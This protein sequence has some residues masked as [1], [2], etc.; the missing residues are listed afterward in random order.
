MSTSN[1]KKDWVEIFILPLVIACVGTFGTYLITGQQSANALTQANS[2][3]QV[4]ILEIFSEKMTHEDPRQ[5]L[6]AIK[7][8][9][10][11]DPELA[12]KMAFAAAETEPEESETRKAATSVGLEAKAIV[13]LQPRIYMHVEGSSEKKA[14]E[15]VE[16]VLQNNGWVVPSI[17]RVGSKSPRQSQLR[18]FKKS[19]KSKAEEIH[20]IL[21]ENGVPT[22]LTYL[23]GYEDT[24]N[25]R[26]MH[27]E[28]WFSDEQP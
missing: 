28:I 5:R 21:V 1:R 8:L 6:L 4:K 3:R 11:L 10:A 20:E 14:A 18:Y 17:E 2:D 25:I 26:P 12:A 9:A 22:L 13:Q 16:N 27:F 23:G 15:K 7:M 19:E 24:N